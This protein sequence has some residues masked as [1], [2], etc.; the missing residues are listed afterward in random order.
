MYTYVIRKENGKN[1]KDFLSF[2]TEN[3]QNSRQLKHSAFRNAKD[4]GGVYHRKSHGFMLG[5]E[6][7]PKFELIQF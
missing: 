3:D 2:W 1:R 7:I 6:L 4:R 5:E